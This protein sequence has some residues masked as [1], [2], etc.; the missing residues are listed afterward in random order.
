MEIF[1]VIR[2]ARWQHTA[3]NVGWGLPCMGHLLYLFWQWSVYFGKLHF[4]VLS[5]IIII[6]FIIIIGPNVDL[7]EYVTILLSVMSGIN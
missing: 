7:N 2:F 1:F 3:M 6:Y 5:I 4:V